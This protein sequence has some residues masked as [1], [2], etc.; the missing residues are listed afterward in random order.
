M[1]ARYQIF[2]LGGLFFLF[3]FLVWLR[4]FFRQQTPAAV[5]VVSPTPFSGAA[6]KVLGKAAHRF[7]PFS[8][9]LRSWVGP[10][11]SASEKGEGHGEGAGK[12]SDGEGLLSLF[13]KTVADDARVTTAPAAP[14][15]PTAA[16]TA[17]AAPEVLGATAKSDLATATP[18]PALTADQQQVESQ[19]ALWGAY[20]VAGNYAALYQMMSQEFRQSF[21]LVDFQNGLAGGSAVSRLELQGTPQVDGDW[22]E[23]PVKVIRLNGH[24]ATYKTVFHRESGSWYL[25]GTE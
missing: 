18:T 16:P 24:T 20:L 25:F 21:S 5:E 14:T 3:L 2:S 6:A 13:L 17:T 12:D 22:A 9:L 23:A 4:F 11:E 19:A 7:S 15:L 10:G 8:Y 1:H